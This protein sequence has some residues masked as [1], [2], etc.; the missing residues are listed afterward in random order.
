MSAKGNIFERYKSKTEI[1]SI[2]LNIMYLFVYIAGVITRDNVW[3]SKY[4]WVK[5]HEGMDV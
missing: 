1:K 3:I 2:Y 5:D 4:W